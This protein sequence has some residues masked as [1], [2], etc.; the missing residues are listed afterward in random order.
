MTPFKRT[1][2]ISKERNKAILT[3]GLQT[4]HI[5]AIHA[6]NRKLSQRKLDAYTKFFPMKFIKGP[7]LSEY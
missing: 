3:Y 6:N 1:K 5:N 2:F 4:F 7:V